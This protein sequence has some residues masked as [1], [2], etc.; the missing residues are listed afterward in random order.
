MDEDRGWDEIHVGIVVFYGLM[1]LGLL[2]LLGMVGS[3]FW[4]V[5]HHVYL[6]LR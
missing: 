1:L 6:W 5:V 2:T 4:W 3:G